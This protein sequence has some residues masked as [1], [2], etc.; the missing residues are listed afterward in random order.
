MF[1]LPSTF[2]CGAG[3]HRHR[4]RVAPRK[5]TKNREIGA[6]S[7]CGPELASPNRSVGHSPRP[8]WVALNLVNAVLPG[9]NVLLHHA[10]KLAQTIAA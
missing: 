2:S 1:M 4:P 7:I 6:T 10:T 3:L 8:P 9:Y 5:V